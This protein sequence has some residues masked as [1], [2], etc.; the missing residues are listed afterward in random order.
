MNFTVTGDAYDRDIYI[1]TSGKA[2]L[3]ECA[4][5]LDEDLML[6]PVPMEVIKNFSEAQGD[7]NLY[8]LDDPTFSEAIF[9]LPVKAEAKEEYNVLNLY[10]NWGKYPLKQL[11]GIPFT[12]PFYH[13]STGVTET[14]CILPYYTAGAISGKGVKNNTLTDFRS[15][16]APYWEGQPQHNS[17]G[18]HSWLEYTDGEGSFCATENKNNT[19]TSY[20]PTYAEVV[21]DYISD[22]G[23]IAVTY[24]HMEMPQTDENRVYYTMEYT[25][26]EDLTI[27]D[28]K[29]DFQFYDATDN[30][31]TGVYKRVGYLNEKNESVVVP[32][33]TKGEAIY[34]LGDNCPYFSFFEMPDWDRENTAA[35]GYSN[36]AFLVYR[37]SFI[38]GGEKSDAGFVIVNEDDHVRISLDLDQVNL[39]AGDKFTI[40][41]ILMPW[42]SQQMEG[43]YDKIQDANVRAVRENTLLNPLKASSDSDEIMESV[44]LPKIKSADGKQATFTLSGGKNNVAVR[45]Y[46]FDLLT[47]PK[48]EELVDGKWVEY[49]LSSK[50]TPDGAGNYHYYD[51][52]AVYY[53]G[54]GTYS[55]SF[56]TDMNGDKSRTFRLT[57]CEEFT[58]WQE[59]EKPTAV[60]EDLLKV[61]VDAVELNNAAQYSIQQFGSV[62]LSADEEY[63]TFNASGKDGAREST[64]LVFA[65]NDGIETGQYV[66]IKYRVRAENPEKIGY[67]ETFLS[68]VNTAPTSGDN[69][70]FVL[71]EDGEWHVAVLD[72]SKMKASLVPK[73]NDGKYYINYMRI[74]VFN[75]PLYKEVAIDIAYVGIDS[76]LKVI[77]DINAREFECVEL[78][79]ARAS[80]NML[81]TS[82]G[83]TD[84]KVYIHSTSGY[85]ESKVAYGAIIDAINGKALSAGF[86]SSREG[87]TSF[88][89]YNAGA[90]KTFTVAGWCGVD[91]GVTKYVW[92][93]DGGK[94]WNEFTGEVKKASTA[95]IE[96]AQQRS[97]ATFADATQSKTNGSFQGSGITADLSAY[98]GQKVDLTIGA[99]PASDADGK[100]IVLLYHFTGVSVP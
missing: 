14:N 83:E 25:V 54:D 47:A 82:T 67:I 85:T 27:Q 50:D 89:G 30:D 45:V 55:Y 5:L 99:I 68:A 51:G 40:H 9:C 77:C 18:A 10:Q 44:Y 37:S 80:K 22:D 2:G 46:G 86:S 70:S 28:F 53:D 48:V 87:M 78:Y 95:I 31:P 63:V 61:Y 88:S 6:L 29:R 75:D 100:S 74:D 26:L 20:G 7:R 38:I 52:Y 32:A 58:P 65:N 13:L 98:S 64:F 42:G 57:A 96:A 23:K 60:R 81:N 15:M 66:V 43:T 84:E 69:T 73:A 39:K 33:V 12:A 90:E 34:R 17:C 16:S 79:K 72:I 91:G 24:T 11:S 35:E 21:M 92:S 41:A 71:A 76:D 62:V 3:L 36:L 97:E 19:I 56:V 1:M 59:E 8:N 93:A 49:V 4:V 94:T